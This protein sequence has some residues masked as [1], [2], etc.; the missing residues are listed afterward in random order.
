MPTARPLLKYG[1]LINKSMLLVLLTIL[2]VLT[3]TLCSLTKNLNLNDLDL[4]V[5]AVDCSKTVM[6]CSIG[7]K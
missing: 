1:R 7:Q 6:Q 2:A 3:V 5:V 4:L